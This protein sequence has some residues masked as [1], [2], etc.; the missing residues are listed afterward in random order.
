M[1][2]T[3]M[4]E[5]IE[6]VED[7]PHVPIFRLSVEQ[8]HEMARAGI[9]TEDDPV[10]LLEGWLVLKMTK[11]PAQRAATRRVRKVLEGL[12]REGCYVDSQEPITLADSEPEPDVMVVHGESDDYQDRHPGPRDVA[13]VV[14]I[15][16]ASLRRDRDWKR[17]LYAAAGIPAYWIV[18]LIERQVEVYTEPEVTKQRTDYRRRQDLRPPAS[19]PVTLAGVEIGQ[20]AVAELLP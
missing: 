10:E 5:P 3:S 2:P 7:V 15:A 20:I 6:R 1:P 14:E 13:L 19:V 4:T 18:N 17:R 8:Y 16:D 11:N 9:L 12:F